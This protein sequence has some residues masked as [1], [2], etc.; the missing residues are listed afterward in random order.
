MNRPQRRAF[1]LIELLVVIA[2]IAIL[3]SILFPVFAQA[4]R[5]AKI[6]SDLSNIKQIN[7]ALIMYTNDYDDRYTFAIP[8]SWSGATQWGSSSLG[9]T[10]S[11]QPYVKSLAL[12]RSPLETSTKIGSWGTWLGIAVSYGINSLTLRNKE[13]GD[14]F[15]D[16]PD[17]WEG[18]C[19]QGSFTNTVQDCTLR[20]IS[21]PGAQI[22]GEYGGGELNTASL[23]VTQVTNPADTIAIATK[24][25]GDALKY[26][27]G[28]GNMTQF[29]CGGFFEGI[30]T[31]DGSNSDD[32]D[33]CGGAEVPNGLIAL[34]V[35]AP[36]GAYGAV[37]QV[38]QGFSNFGM[39]DGHAKLLNIASTDPDPDHFPATLSKNKWDALR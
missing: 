1:T 15:A 30:P 9:W 31:T 27:P 8:E 21:A 12:F 25:N 5:S 11:L 23:A 37:S 34:T 16:G 6:T 32:L 2:I 4:K 17:S 7:T 29:Q 19:L 38:R 26:G 36:D 13:I 14:N 3:A 35:A 28:V 18:R 10:L 20:G 22:F 33:W 24:F 39:T